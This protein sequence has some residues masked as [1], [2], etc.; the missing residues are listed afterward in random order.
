MIRVLLGHDPSATRARSPGYTG[1]RFDM[2]DQFL[3]I[4]LMVVTAALHIY[5]QTRAEYGSKNIR[6][7]LS[8]TGVGSAVVFVVCA[9]VVWPVGTLLG[10][11]I[12]VGFI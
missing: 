5:F 10:Y 1:P 3:A 12:R 7:A 2:C 11:H 8:G 6:G 9:T 4:L